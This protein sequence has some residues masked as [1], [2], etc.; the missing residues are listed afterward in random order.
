MSKVSLVYDAILTA[1]AALFPNKRRIP[2]ALVIEENPEQLLRDGYGLKVD[3]EAPAESEFCNFSRNRIFT[4]LLSKEVIKTDIQT[5]QMD[6][7]SKA[8]LEDVYTLQKDFM[9]PDQITIEESIE[10]IEMAGTSAITPF[11]GD[12]ENFISVE[13]SFQIQITDLI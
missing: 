10:Q 13:V 7:A 12:R 2:N 11:V 8:L 3:A 6:T 1:T 5:T 4:I 9:N